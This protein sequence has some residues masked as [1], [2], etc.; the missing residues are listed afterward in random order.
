MSTRLFRVLA[1]I[2]GIIGV[3]LLITS[4][5]II[6]N[7]PAHPTVAQLV[8]YKNQ[9]D[10]PFVIGCWLQAVSPVLIVLFAF[11]VVRL[12]G[13][14]NHLVGW[15]TFFGGV[16][17]VMVSLV[18]VTFYLSAI[19]GNPATTSLISLDLI[20]AVQ[21]LYSIVA[22]PI[23]FFPLSLVFLSSPVLRKVIGAIV[24]CIG[25]AIGAAFSILGMIGL[26]TPDQNVVNI[27]SIVQGNWWLFA[28]IVLIFW[29]GKEIEAPAIKMAE[30]VPAI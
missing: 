14:Q 16:I 24:A 28:A 5:I 17:L 23:L 8:A 4:F 10:I 29:P 26:F 3:L 22:A 25:F 11:S 9:Y 18:E 13:K 21:H 27:M 7:P 1:A 30:T 12:A 15:M 2:C 19:N 20:A 6:P